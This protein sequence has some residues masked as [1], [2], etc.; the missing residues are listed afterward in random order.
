MRIAYILYPEVI[1]SNRSNGIRSQA[2]TWAELLREEGHSVDL[3]SNWGNY[4][5]SDYDIIHL[6][7]GGKWILTFSRRMYELNKK[8]VWSP[9][10]DPMVKPY[11]Y[12]KINISRT[13]QQLSGNRYEWKY[14]D[15]LQ[16]LPYIRKIY[17]RSLFEMEH[18]KKLFG[19]VS[20]KISLVP[21][22][23]SNSCI[24]YQEVEKENFCFHV[25]SIYQPRKNVVRLIEASKK[26][27]FRLV[28]AGN[29]GS[30]E[31]FKFLAEAI[32]EDENIK[33]LG[34][35]SEEEKID[36]YKRAKVFALPSISEGVGI[37]ALDAAYYGCEIVI[38]NIS[39]PKEYYRGKCIE[40]DPLNID[41]IG[42]AIMEFLDGKKKFQ[43]E[44]SLEITQLFSG[45]NIAQKLIDS[46]K[47]I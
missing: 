22:S 6:F 16:A 33:V 21:L 18:I 13:L 19:I 35:I 11:L 42:M 26:Y 38:T 32:G 39:G 5:W 25:S 7:G 17:V 14:S 29:K 8:I 36:L 37:V 31:Q 30:D 1:I 28:L 43:P 44:M 27:G 2:E 20:D 34:F 12:L 4:H 10:I 23:Y 41:S 9:I 15:A 45:A 46:Y 40:V 3:I 24:P 47:S